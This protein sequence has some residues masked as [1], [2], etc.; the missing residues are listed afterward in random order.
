MEA[1]AAVLTSLTRRPLWRDQVKISALC[2]ELEDRFG[3]HV[4]AG[5]PGRGRPGLSPGEHRR[6]E[7][8]GEVPDRVRLGRIVRGAA[9]GTTSEAGFITALRRSGVAVRPRYDS[10]DKTNVVGYSVA[11]RSGD[12][13]P[14][15]WYG[16]GRLGKG[17]TLPQLRQWWEQSPAA[18]REALELWRGQSATGVEIAEADIARVAG[19]SARLGAIGVE[20]MVSWQ[21][22]APEIAGVLSALA[23]RYEGSTP[24]PIGAAADLLS[25]VAPSHEPAAPGARSVAGG[26]GG[27][28]AQLA[29]QDDTLGWVLL[30]RQMASTVESYQSAGEATTELTEAVERLDALRRELEE[31][32]Q[33][34]TDDTAVKTAGR[35]VEDH[36]AR[37]ERAELD[38]EPPPEHHGPEQLSR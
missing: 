33:K 31:H 32:Y 36:L 8:A 23:E 5:R 13:R 38:D 28:A 7:R 17:L 24:G 10:A 20:D 22:A 37:G 3:L 30:L 29:V 2:A 1:F 27:T 19:L 25:Q 9:A 35:H 18:Q 4:V 12:Q 26:G 34:A 16:G 15:L 6:A 14:A 11:L 21:A